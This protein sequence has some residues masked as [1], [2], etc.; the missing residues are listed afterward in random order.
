ML[1]DGKGK[2]KQTK[3]T[4]IWCKYKQILK[5]FDFKFLNT[6]ELRL[7]FYQVTSFVCE[8]HLDICEHRRQRLLK[9][10]PSDSIFVFM[11]SIYYLQK[12]SPVRL[13]QW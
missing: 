1:R 6:W 11:D 2:F 4:C 8:Q 7:S 5:T 13:L 3:C 10:Y 9:A 12:P